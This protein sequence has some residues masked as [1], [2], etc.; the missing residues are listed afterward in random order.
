MIKIRKR[1]SIIWL[2]TILTFGLIV[3][4][5]VGLVYLIVLFPEIF[6]GIF[7]CVLGLIIF[8]TFIL[9]IKDGI[10]SYF[11]KR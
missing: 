10:E 5:V 11:N 4:T 1:K 9:L 6:T 2:L 8:G 3:T 7:V